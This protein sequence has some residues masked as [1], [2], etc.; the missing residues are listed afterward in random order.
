MADLQIVGS[1]L[2]IFQIKISPF[3]DPPARM[4]GS[5]GWNSMLVKQ[6][7]TS[8]V[9]VGFLQSNSLLKILHMLIALLCSHHEL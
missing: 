9:V 4:S 1:S 8:I 5:L 2:S 7:D 3:K 6:F